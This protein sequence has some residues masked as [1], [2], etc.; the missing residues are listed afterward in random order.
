MANF[1]KNFS[2]IILTLF[3][4]LFSRYTHLGGEDVISSALVFGTLASAPLMMISGKMISLKYNDSSATNFED[5]ECKTAYGFSILTW[6]G[7]VWVLYIFV[8]SG[9]VLSR[10]HRFTLLL[11]SSQMLVSLV[12]IVWSNMSAVDPLWGDIHAVLALL[13]G[14]MSRCWVLVIMLNV[15]AIMSQKRVLIFDEELKKYLNID[16]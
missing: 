7:C 15:L 8:A 10:L 12:H 11:L 2:F 9:R 4:L 3:L 1:Y 14:F 16:N 5:I 6:F 13:S